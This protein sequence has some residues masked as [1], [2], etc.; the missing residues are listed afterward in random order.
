MPR[1]N[2]TYPLDSIEA[3]LNGYAEASADGYSG[4]GMYGRTCASINFDTDTDAYQFFA[5]LGEVTAFDQGD[6]SA[7]IDGDPTV[8]L[9]ELV[10][11]ALTDSM[12]R[13]IV[14]YFPGWVFA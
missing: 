7:V 1:Q 14:V 2:R 10:G 12:G 8:R 13:G 5:R 3:A 9:Q 4:R 6:A 11:C